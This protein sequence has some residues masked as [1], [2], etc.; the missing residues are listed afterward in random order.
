MICDLKRCSGQP[1]S[2]VLSSPKGWM[3]IYL[4]GPPGIQQDGQSFIPA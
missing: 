2:R 4:R 3:I 1:V